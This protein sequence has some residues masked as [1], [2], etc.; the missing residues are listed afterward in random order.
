MCGR[1]TRKRRDK[2]HCRTGGTGKLH[3][4]KTAIRKLGQFSIDVAAEVLDDAV[5]ETIK[6]RH[7]ILRQCLRRAIDTPSVQQKITPTPIPAPTPTPTTAPH[8]AKPGINASFSRMNDSDLSTSFHAQNIDITFDEHDLKIFIATVVI[9]HTYL[10]K[11]QFAGI[12]ADDVDGYLET[13]AGDRRRVIS[14][15]WYVWSIYNSSVQ[16]MIQQMNQLCPGPNSYYYTQ[17][18]DQLNRL[19]D[20]STRVLKTLKDKLGDETLSTRPIK[21]AFDYDHIK[22]FCKIMDMY[23]DENM[24]RL[25]QSDLYP[26]I[27]QMMKVYMNGEGFKIMSAFA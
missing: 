3:G 22:Q 16:L 25:Y 23:D 9:Y 15:I 2:K 24:I 27:K 26:E 12:T 13:F 4:V 1:K 17:L 6:G 20:V 19:H 7:K 10:V 14:T 8:I 21:T 18:L 5:K 11:R